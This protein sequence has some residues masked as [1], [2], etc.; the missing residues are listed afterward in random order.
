MLIQ[1]EFVSGDAHLSPGTGHDVH[2]LNS[3][4]VIDIL[5][6]EILFFIIYFSFKNGGGIFMAG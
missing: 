2:L 5:I 3:I 6:C 1:V 4:V